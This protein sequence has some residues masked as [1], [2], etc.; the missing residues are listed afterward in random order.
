MLGNLEIRLGKLCQLEEVNRGFLESRKLA[1]VN[2]T[3][4]PR[5][6]A[7]REGAKEPQVLQPFKTILIEYLDSPNEG[8]NNSNM[9]A[10]VW[11][12][13]FLPEESRSPLKCHPEAEQNETI[14][15]QVVGKIR[16][17]E[18]ERLLS[19]QKFEN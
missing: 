4:T 3:P 19:W 11:R 7:Q 15:Y 1:A 14:C 9:A 8:P 5:H 16:S 6:P 10:G 12:T 2:K 17:G 13:S 18:I